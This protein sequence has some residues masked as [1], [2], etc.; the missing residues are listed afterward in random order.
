MEV[1]VTDI[2]ADIAC[3][4]KASYPEL[5]PWKTEFADTKSSGW[6]YK[7]PALLV[8]PSAVYLEPYNAHRLLDKVLNF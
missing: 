7:K 3:T 2:L 6:A 4:Q 5:R 1:G 8:I